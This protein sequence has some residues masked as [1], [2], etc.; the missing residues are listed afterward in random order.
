MVGDKISL[1]IVGRK[2][3]REEDEGR[4]WR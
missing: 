4:G 1:V 2:R 3:R